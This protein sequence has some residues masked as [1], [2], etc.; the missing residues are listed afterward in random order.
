M[1]AGAACAAAGCSQKNPTH[2]GRFRGQPR[3]NHQREC[4][5][6]GDVHNM[7]RQYLRQNEV[8][9][10]CQVPPTWRTRKDPLEA[11]SIPRGD[12]NSSCQA[13]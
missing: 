9:E 2:Q 11:V 5:E 13:K 1:L 7:A 3:K 8:M 10:Q 6:G 12:G 4:N